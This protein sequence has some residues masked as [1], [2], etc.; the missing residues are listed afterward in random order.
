MAEQEDQS[1]KTEEPSQKKLDDA[2]KKGDVPKSQEVSSWFTLI[3]ITIAT[4]V[5]AVSM[6]QDISRSLSTFLMHAHDIPVDGRALISFF[7][8]V[9]GSVM[10]AMA[11]PLLIIMVMAVLGNLVQHRPVLSAERMKPK[12]NK[13]SLIQGAK[14]L[15][16]PTSLVNF[17]KGMAKICIVSVVIFLIVWP[18][19][20]SLDVVVALPAISLISMFY[21]MAVR[22]LIAVA[23]VMSVVAA[24]D[25]IYQRQTWM[26]KQRMSFKEIKDEYK[27]TEGDPHVKAKIRALRLERSRKRMMANVPG[28]TVVVTNPTH[29]AVALK[30]ENG[31]DA[32]ICVAKGVDAVALRIRQV[33]T[34]NEVPIV[35][36]KPLARALHASVEVDEVIPVEHYQA[37]AEV[38]GFVMRMKR[39]R[40]WAA[41]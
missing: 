37:V 5:F 38:I 40:V 21:E 18:E 14:R 39:G 26:K 30:Y 33:A 15:F 7:R 11:I 12:L 23:A 16:S 41:E 35:E 36:N 3:G 25:F 10:L 1:E 8:E 31:M 13:I 20:D 6:T 29:F 2:H 19:R 4:L 24:L 27:Q 17:A 32:P 34:D 28:A 9:I 22:I